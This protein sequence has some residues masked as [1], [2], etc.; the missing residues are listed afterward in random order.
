MHNV[1]FINM[2]QTFTKRNRQNSMTSYCWLAQNVNG[3]QE[4][5]GNQEVEAVVPYHS[6]AVTPLA[7]LPNMFCDLYVSCRL[8]YDTGTTD[9]DI[10]IDYRD[11]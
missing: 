1:S 2:G 3:C 11:V 8:E 5:D 10:A 7:F 9:F 6:E 4:S